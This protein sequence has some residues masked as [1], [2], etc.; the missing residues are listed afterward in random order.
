[1]FAKVSRACLQ[2]DRIRPSIP[3]MSGRQLWQR[4]RADASAL[5]DRVLRRQL[6]V[7]AGLAGRLIAADS[8]TLHRLGAE[9]EVV[10]W[11]EPPEWRATVEHPGGDASTLLASKIAGKYPHDATGP[12]G[13]LTL[14]DVLLHMPS[15]VHTAGGWLVRESM[16][17]PAVLANPKYWALIQSLDWR[18][19]RPLAPGIL[20]ALTW[21]HNFYHWMVEILPRLSMLSR[22]RPDLPLYVGESTPRFAA[23]SLELLGLDHRVVWLPDGVYR[24]E[25]LVVPSRMSLA[26]HPTRA[27]IDWL[28]DQLRNRASAAGPGRLIYASRRDAAIRFAANEDEVVAT[29]ARLGFEEVAFSTLGLAEQIK[30]M[31]SA[32]AVVGE[33]GAALSHLAFA[34]DGG[35]LVELFEEGHAMPCFYHLANL[36]RFSY[37]CMACPREGLGYHVDVAR[38]EGLVRRM[39]RGEPEVRAQ[40]AHA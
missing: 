28:R 29:L 13:L 15:A 1:L 24:A 11:S 23:A 9:F 34:H 16:L 4:F 22:C 32:R 39:M 10:D 31:S 12:Y 21:N 26:L 5:G 38:L 30:V 14:P 19:A 8:E 40:A 33:H 7:G 20:V 37:G 25:S 6:E 18:H 36:R 27:A 2:L 3:P 17:S 35:M